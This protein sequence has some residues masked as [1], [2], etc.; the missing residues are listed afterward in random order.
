MKSTDPWPRQA[1]GRLL[2]VVSILAGVALAAFALGLAQFDQARQ[3]IGL[4]GI[5]LAALALL[6]YLA[7]RSV[8]DFAEALAGWLGRK[9]RATAPGAPP[10]D[11]SPRGF[12]ATTEKPSGRGE[13]GP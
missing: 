3:W 11:D 1:F 9:G 10:V 2:T 5:G 4:G 8:S 13:G 6:L 7:R 12:S